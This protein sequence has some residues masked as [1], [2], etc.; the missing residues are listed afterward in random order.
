MPITLTCKHCGTGFSR[1]PSQAHIQ[2]C[3]R[4]C[5]LTFAK[6]K[7][8]TGKITRENRP[9]VTCGTVFNA[10]PSA[11][12]CSRKCQQDG[13][14]ECPKRRVPR[15]TVKCIECGKT[16]Q[17]L[18]CQINSGRGRTCS[19]ACRAHYSN[20]V[21]GKKPSGAES[22]FF[23]AC[24]QSGAE[25]QLQVRIGPYC[26]DAFSSQKRIVFEFDGEYWHSL[27]RAIRRDQQKDKFL[28]SLGYTVI[29]IPERLSIEKPEAARGLVMEAL[30]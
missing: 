12:Y 23:D 19:K 26:V 29:R 6:G 27:P 18:Q 16:F 8:L 7:G 13:R 11:K 25:L 3:S 9:C 30:Q 15:I 24:I 14:P 17:K 5:W 20:R 4:N 22:R 1:T 21:Q 2:F 28:K 10:R